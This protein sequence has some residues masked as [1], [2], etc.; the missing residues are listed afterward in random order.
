MRT[1]LKNYFNVFKSKKHLFNS[2]FVKKNK[3]NRIFQRLGYAKAMP[4]GLHQCLFNPRDIYSIQILSNSLCRKKKLI[5]KKKK[6][7]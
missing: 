6:L 1:C 2:K 3:E 5:K 7:P 4:K